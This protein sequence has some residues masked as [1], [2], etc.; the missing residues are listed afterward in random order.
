MSFLNYVV[1]LFKSVLGLIYGGAAP[2][3]DQFEYRGKDSNTGKFEIFC[4]KPVKEISAQ[5]WNESA[6]SGPENR[7]EQRF[8]TLLRESS[9]SGSDKLSLLVGERHSVLPHCDFDSRIEDGNHGAVIGLSFEGA[10]IS[11]GFRKLHLFVVRPGKDSSLT[12]TLLP[13]QTMTLE[14]GDRVHVGLETVI[15]YPK[16]Q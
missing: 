3:S 13:R 6:L 10:Y 8:A 1:S 11:N 7:F 5:W 14:P 2:S 12:F 16:E 15:Y 9:N 4:P